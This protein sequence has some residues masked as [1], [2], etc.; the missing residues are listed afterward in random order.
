MVGLLPPPI[1]LWSLPNI[2]LFLSLSVKLKL[3][4]LSYMKVERQ[5]LFSLAQDLVVVVVSHE[6]QT[7]FLLLS[8]LL[9][10]LCPSL[11]HG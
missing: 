7:P 9:Y 3:V 8:S 2:P 11:P 10:T 1:G 4:Q 6:P 5:R